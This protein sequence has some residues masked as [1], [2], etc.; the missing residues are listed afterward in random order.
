M[1][2]IVYRFFLVSLTSKDI[3]IQ[4]LEEINYGK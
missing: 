2:V 4:F 3:I 1:K